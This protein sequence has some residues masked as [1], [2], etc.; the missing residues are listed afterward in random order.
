MCS[1]LKILLFLFPVCLFGTEPG[2]VDT[3]NGRVTITD[4]RVAIGPRSSHGVITNYFQGFE[5][6]PYTTGAKDDYDLQGW[7]VYNSYCRGDINFEAAPGS[8]NRAIWFTRWTFFNK[9]DDS[10]IITPVIT[11]ANDVVHLKFLARNKDLFKGVI[12]TY[13]SYSVNPSTNFGDANEWTLVQTNLLES[14]NYV[15]YNIAF[16]NE[17][18]LTNPVFR[19]MI[20]RLRAGDSFAGIDCIS[21]ESPY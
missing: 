11:N 6:W 1:F 17:I 8:T 20:L 21:I 4:G 14:T 2:H 19:A 15:A 3:V 18:T 9:T 7:Q 13:F 12:A 10:L 16:T 5:D